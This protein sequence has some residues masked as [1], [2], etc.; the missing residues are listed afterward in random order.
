MVKI[1]FFLAFV[2]LL[3][4]LS[5]ELPHDSFSLSSKQVLQEA[6]AID[7][8]LDKAHRKQKLEIPSDLEDGQLLRRIYL[9]VAGRIPS[10]DETTAF[11]NHRS[12]D[13]KAML[14]DYLLNSPAY[15]SQMFNWWADL[16]RLQSR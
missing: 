6:S 13:Q 11:F 7:R 10:F 16:L 14:V 1:S 15:E 9:T 4:P 12:E 5:G 2:S 8:I 3:L